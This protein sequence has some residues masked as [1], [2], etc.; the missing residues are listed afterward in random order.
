MDEELTEPTHRTDRATF[1]P[2]RRILRSAIHHKTELI[3]I[4]SFKCTP[5][6]A[7]KVTGGIGAQA[8]TLTICQ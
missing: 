2:I 5:L 7:V 8:N 3:G 1:N 4:D 6:P